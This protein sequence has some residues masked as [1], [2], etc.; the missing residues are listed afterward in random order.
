MLPS[1][2]MFLGIFLYQN[3]QAD[4]AG[5]ELKA[6]LAAHPDNPE[7]LIW[8]GTVDLAQGQPD[9]A[10][11]ALDHAY[12]LTPDDLNLL[13][14]RGRAH[15]TV[16]MDSSARMA[17]LEPGNWHV[18]RVQGELFASEGK[19]AEAAAEFTAAIKLQPRD[20]DL[21]EELGD[22]Y[23]STSQLDQAEAAYKTGLDLG[24]ANPVAMY[25]LGSA[26]IENGDNAAGV[27]LLEAM[28]RVFP[29]SPVA[30][31]YL[32]RGLSA[33]DRN[34]EAAAW[35]RKSANGAD[36]AEITKRSFYELTRVY[37]KLH[38]TEDEQT[39]L[40][41]YNRVRFAQEQQSTKQVQ[42]WKRLNETN[43]AGAMEKPPLRE[44]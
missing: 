29:G 13:E 22:E 38:Q 2:H 39:A 6:E 17:R 18:H 25:N 42:D 24:P 3:N 9:D 40:A 23:R 34:E 4:E 12:R 26:E 19:H 8:L 11:E 41:N 15:R 10:T 20:P 31:Y 5:H 33:L 21:Y 7:A 1:A 32:G 43:E 37:R 44:P 14:M 35:L 16:A 27:P 28:L 30:E 36:L